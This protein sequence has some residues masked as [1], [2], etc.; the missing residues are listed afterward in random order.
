MLTL[1]ENDSF[2]SRGFPFDALAIQIEA[3]IMQLDSPPRYS[4]R[5]G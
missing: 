1:S 2:D 4:L 3:E 5:L